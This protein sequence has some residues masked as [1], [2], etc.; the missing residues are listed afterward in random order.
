MKE[1]VQK[2][3][4]AQRFEESFELSLKYYKR[5]MAE[6][7]KQVNKRSQ[8]FLAAKT[9]LKQKHEDERKEIEFNFQAKRAEFTKKRE[10]S[11]VPLRQQ[12]IQL[13]KMKSLIEEGEKNEKLNESM[14]PRLR[15]SRTRKSRVANLALPPLSK[16]SNA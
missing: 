3:I 13:R 2:M 1:K 14:Q 6:H 11:L 5:Q 16:S 10:Q 15:A 8:A 12:I 9:A 7:Q 4:K